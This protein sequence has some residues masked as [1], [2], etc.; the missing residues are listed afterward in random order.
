MTTATA[1]D[2]QQRHRAESDVREDY[3]KGPRRRGHEL[4]DAILE[5]TM[6]ELAESGYAELSMERVATRAHASKGS[7]YRRWPNRAE[8]VGDA[9]QRKRANPMAMPDTGSVRE[10]LLGY[11]SGMA[12]RVNSADG[13]AVRG[14]LAETMCDPEFILMIRRRLIDPNIAEVLELLRR[15]AVRGEVRPTALTRQ[16]AGVG[17]NLLGQHFMV[18]GA[19]I[20]DSVLVEIVDDI[21]MPLI[22]F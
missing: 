4:V 11:L 9:L 7:L 8:L 12:S 1:G 2:A 21:L 5:A 15:G 10:D 17:P 16:I 20:A 18:Y 14:L 22:S 6:A 13:E 19:P 3:R